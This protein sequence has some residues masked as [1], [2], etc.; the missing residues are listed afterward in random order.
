MTEI[1]LLAMLFSA[2]GKI[3]MSLASVIQKQSCD[4][5]PK[6]GSIPL[7][8]TIM[9][10]IKN[11]RWIFGA[12]LAS[13]GFPAWM[14]AFHFGGLI[15]TQPMASIGIL[16]IVVYSLKVLK[17]KITRTETAGI[18][19]IMVGPVFL[20]FQ[21]IATEKIEPNLYVII[22]L[23]FLIYVIIAALLL[24][25][26]TMDAGKRKA[27]VYAF[28]VGLIISMAALSGRLSA[29]YKG[30]LPLIFILLVLIHLGL[31]TIILQIMYQQ[32]RAVITITILNILAIAFPVIAGIV[33]LGE[34]I[35]SILGIG[36]IVIII[37][38]VLVSRVGYINE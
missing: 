24:L 1:P 13:I 11:R 17:E 9:A 29:L 35:N 15:Y 37:G 8:E 7:K 33:I 19:L 31:G 32:G 10:F 25:S 16:T 12:V 3:L 38:C 4:N 36:I 22:L 20:G 28:A 21:P 23:Y 18:L 5:I 6:I 27:V 34:K 30:Y 2:I 14:I 26:R